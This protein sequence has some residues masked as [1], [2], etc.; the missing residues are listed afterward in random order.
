M[1]RS[2]G[3]I[4]RPPTD[5][6]RLRAAHLDVVLDDEPGQ[7]ADEVARLLLL[8]QQ[9]GDVRRRVD[10]V[11]HDR[12][13]DD[14]E[15]RVGA[16][17]GELPDGRRHQEADRD[18]DVEVVVAEVRQ[19]RDVVGLG[20]RLLHL[21]GDAE[22]VLGLRRALERELV[23]ALVVQAALIGCEPD[24]DGRAGRRARCCC[25]R[26]AGGR[27]GGGCCRLARRAVIRRAACGADGGDDEGEQRNDCALALQDLLLQLRVRRTLTPIP[28][29][30]PDAAAEGAYRASPHLAYRGSGG[31]PGV[32]NRAT[33]SISMRQPNRICATPTVVR[34]GACPGP[35]MRRRRDPS[36]RTRSGRS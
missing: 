30:P 33:Q 10:R 31:Q 19:V 27:G 14:R 4:L 29:I 18:D 21:E 6:T 34:A 9:A 11:A 7:V 28:R 36:A 16:L 20:L 22:L 25:R 13:V 23:E 1:N 2:T 24:L 26:V 3:G 32:R 15:L 12:V 35:E 17:R 5:E 8:E